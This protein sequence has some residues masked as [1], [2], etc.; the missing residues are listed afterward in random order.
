M[1]IHC[2]YIPKNCLYTAYF[3]AFYKE[4]YMLKIIKT[5]FIE[6]GLFFKR[7]YRD[8]II[9]SFATL[10]LVLCRYN[11]IG[12]R[13]INHLFYYVFC[14]VLTCIIFLRENPL[15]FGLSLGNYK[16]WLVHV[17]VV[18]FISIPILF[19]ASHGFSIKSYYTNSQHMLKY[20]LEMTAVLF[21]WEFILR[22]FMLFGLRKTFKEMS[23]LI[24]MVPFAILHIGKPEIET[25]V[26]IFMG[27]YFGYVAYRSN[28]FW[29]AFIIHLYIY[30]SLYFFVNF[31]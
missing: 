22:S 10:F 24:Q 23:I 29:P 3:L 7:N 13:W 31:C 21:A 25:I 5:E 18:I 28:S 30:L 2:G 4:D 26:C 20:F 11:P 14:P 19:I 9:I 6:F 16:L 1:Y 8:I 27:I 15:N 17:L 12:E